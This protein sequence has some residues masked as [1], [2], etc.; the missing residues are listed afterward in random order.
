AECR[1]FRVERWDLESGR[2]ASADGSFA[3]IAVIEGE[4]RCGSA[5]F[6]AGDFFLI[7]A[8][9]A[10]LEVAP[11]VGSAAILRTTIPDV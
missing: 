5:Q 10:Q 6:A 11:L 1:E 9:H 2:R 4:V 7:P 3:I 8:V